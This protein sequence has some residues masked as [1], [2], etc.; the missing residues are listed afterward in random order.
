MKIAFLTSFNSALIKNEFE[1]FLINNSIEAECFWSSFE[2]QGRD[3]FD[4]N[5]LLYKFEPNIIFIH[6]EVESLLGDFCNDL[7]LFSIDERVKRVE[8]VTEKL[9]RNF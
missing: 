3:I 9:R 1:D 7:L 5:S 4:K 2:T 6:Y 8:E